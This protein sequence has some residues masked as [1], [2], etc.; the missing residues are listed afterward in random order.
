[1]KSV[2]RRIRDRILTGLARQEDIDHLYNQFAG[3]IQIQNAIRGE[4]VLLPMRGWAISPDA[5]AWVL[6]DLQERESPTVVEFGSGQSTIV[7][8]AVL[9]SR[10]GRLVSVEHDP[11]HSDVIQRQAKACGLSDVIHFVHSPLVETEIGCRSY[12]TA[13]IP[14]GPFD[15]ALVDGP[16]ISNGKL[17]RLIPLRWAAARL[18]ERGVIFLDDTFRESEKECLRL[19]KSE[20]PDF[21]HT[22]RAAEKGL[23]EIRSG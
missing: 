7:L 12:D 9:K 14:G 15:V 18:T 17:T 3:L 8:A 23:V 2:I 10:Q 6:A 22:E 20:Y 13:S 11:S 19:F 16:P 5:M 4:P 21:K 1:M